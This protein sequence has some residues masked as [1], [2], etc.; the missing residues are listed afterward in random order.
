[1]RAKRAAF[2]LTAAVLAAACSD[3]SSPTTPASGAVVVGR[4]EQTAPEGAAY[5]VAN[6]V[7]G[8]AGTQASAQT[9]AIGTLNSD[10]TLHEMA[11]ADVKADG[12]FTISGVPSNEDNLVVVARSQAGSAVGRATVYASTRADATT[13]VAPITYQTTLQTLAYARLKATGRAQATS[14]EEMALLVRPDDGAA[15]T[16]LTDGDVDATADAAADASQT[17]TTVFAQSGVSM[18]ASAR[19]SLMADA[20]QAFAEARYSGTASETAYDTYMKA[21]LDAY[22]NAGVAMEDLTEATAGAATTFDAG[23]RG[24][25]TARGQLVSDAVRLNLK[26]RERLAAEFQSTDQGALA[27]SIMNVLANTDA[28]VRGASTAAELRASMDAGMTAVTDSTVSATMGM[29]LP[30]ILTGTM[31]DNV[32][33]KAQAAADT[34]RLAVR[35]QAAANANAAAQ[36]MASYRSDV[37]AAVEAMLQAANRTDVDADAMTSLYIAAYGGAWI[38]AS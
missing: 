26:A 13:E 32:K 7:I 37:H 33:A 24:K 5:P 10:G 6:D 20:A 17:I 8:Q 21:T 25:T 36:A 16:I 22:A 38:Q 29:L 12:S 34:A 2:A 30:G 19:A 3:N 11:Q 28:S 1:M 15:A 9:V 14:A 35:L 4:V 31:H 23:L 27:V 18:D